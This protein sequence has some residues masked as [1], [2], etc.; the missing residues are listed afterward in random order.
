MGLDVWRHP[1][2]HIEVGGGSEESPPIVLVLDPGS[3]FEVLVVHRF[4][5]ISPER[6]TAPRGQGQEQRKKDD[7]RDMGPWP[8]I[9]RAPPGCRV[10]SI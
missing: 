1:V 10:R 9:H 4:R 5:V 2:V 7:H 3:H 8:G 6:R